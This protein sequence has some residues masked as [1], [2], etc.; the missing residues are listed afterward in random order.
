M[1]RL[2]E[3]SDPMTDAS[4][5]A[6]LASFV[7]EE[8]TRTSPR[9]R[10]FVDDAAQGVVLLDIAAKRFDV[11]LMNALFGAGSAQAKNKFDATYPRTKNHVYT[12]FVER[13]IERIR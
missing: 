13:G 5:T 10:L 1:R 12:A 8:G 6:A 3:I 2:L 4:R 7:A 9:R 11:V